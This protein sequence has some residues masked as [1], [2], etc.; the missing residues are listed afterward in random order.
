MDDPIIPLTSDRTGL[1]DAAEDLDYWCR[2][3][4]L[5]NVGMIW[6]WRVLSP[7]EPFTE[8]AAYS[9][10]LWKKAIILMTDGDNNLFDK[11]GT[12]ATSDYTAYGRLSDNELGTTSS[13]EAKTEVNERMEEICTAMKEKGITIYTVTFA[14]NINETTKGYYERCASDPGKYYDA[15]TQ[16]DLS[17]AFETIAKQLSNL[18][19]TE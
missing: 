11:G 6:G 13:T 2:G 15:P 1:T 14:S 3:G 5:S 12:D 16:E 8:G 4:T 9:N 10:L 18:H 19:I 7:T 17:E